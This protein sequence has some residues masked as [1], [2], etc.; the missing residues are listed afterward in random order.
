MQDLISSRNNFYLTSVVTEDS[1]LFWSKGQ[2][3]FL[4]LSCT[5][6]KNVY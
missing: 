6:L 5:R 1:V 4:K 2:R 3:C